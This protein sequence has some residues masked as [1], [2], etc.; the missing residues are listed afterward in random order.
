M[1]DPSSQ[2]PDIYGQVHPVETPELIESKLAEF[3]EEVE[4]IPL[5]KR[6]SLLLAQ[7]KCPDQLTRAYKLKFLRADT[8]NAKLAAKRYVNSWT[9][10]REIGGDERAF[11]PLTL[12][13]VV[14][15]DAVPLKLGMLQ[16]VGTKD[17]AG[18][19]IL[20]LNPA[21]QNWDVTNIHAMARAAAYT[22]MAALEDEETQRKGIVVLVWP[23]NEKFSQV[24]KEFIWLLASSIKGA[25][26]VRL[27]GIHMCQP[28]LFFRVVYPFAQL[29]LGER[30]RKRLMLHPGSQKDMLKTLAPYGLTKEVLP[31]E[32]GGDIVLDH[33]KWLEQR[34]REGK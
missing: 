22:L 34:R 6:E 15:D 12:D 23:K 18:R 3:E 21:M 5:G 24:R 33:D 32:L 30:L 29:V 27:A 28:P 26:P 25:M 31:T 19:S 17:P 7:E 20:F 4:K 1:A 9:V 14:K 16:I 2:E 13:G 11:L 8:F 10:R